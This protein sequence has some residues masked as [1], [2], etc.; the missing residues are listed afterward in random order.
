MVSSESSIFHHSVRVML[1]DSTKI[2]LEE[3]TELGDLS[4]TDPEDSEAENA[5]MTA[6]LIQEM[7]AA[8]AAAVAGVERF[9]ELSGLHVNWRVPCDSW[10]DISFDSTNLEK[11]RDV[12]RIL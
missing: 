5:A 4:A 1:Q 8:Q 6:E 3:P 10:S 7:M 2:Q 12:E 9:R 11:L